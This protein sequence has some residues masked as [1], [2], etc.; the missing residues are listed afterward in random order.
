MIN[1]FKG[2]GSASYSETRSLGKFQEWLSKETKARKGQVRA[3][4]LCYYWGCG[5]ELR[6]DWPRDGQ[7]QVGNWI[8]LL[9]FFLN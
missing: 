1:F 2:T 9:S 3:T 5:G 8:L 6:I 4:N 7:E